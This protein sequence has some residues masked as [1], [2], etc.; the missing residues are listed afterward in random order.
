MRGDME[1]GSSS[2]GEPTR[3][4]EREH[5]RDLS[6]DQLLR[7]LMTRR[8]FG[9]KG[10]DLERA[11]V[12]DAVPVGNVGWIA[13]VDVALSDGVERYQLTLGGRGGELLEGL[14]DERF[15]L[16]IGEVIARG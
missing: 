10:R 15:R 11:Q 7:C 4:R 1:R 2:G 14:E 9:A 6:S 12:V 8:W 5:V 16:A 3:A 13:R